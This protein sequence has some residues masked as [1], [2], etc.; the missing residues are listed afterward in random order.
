MVVAVPQMQ[1]VVDSDHADA[2]DDDA[3]DDDV[4]A[5]VLVSDDDNVLAGIHFDPVVVV[6]I[7]VAHG[8]GFAS[9]QRVGAP[10][11]VVVGTVAVVQGND[12]VDTA[13][14]DNDDAAGVVVVAD[15]A[16]VGA[17]DETM[18]DGNDDDVG[19]A[20]VVDIAARKLQ[21]KHVAVLSIVSLLIQ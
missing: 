7:Q 20:V 13:D 15:V 12:V 11:A 19:D 3:V 1:V 5:V 2:D 6:N 9:S 10:R 14:A 8:V 4:V 16:A 21:R 17:V 18:T